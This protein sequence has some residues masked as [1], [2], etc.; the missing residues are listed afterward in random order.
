MANSRDQHY[1][2]KFGDPTTGEADDEIEGS[3]LNDW[4]FNANTVDKVLDHLMTNGIKTRGGDKLGKTIIFARNHKHAIYIEERFNLNYPEYSGKFLRVIDNYDPKAEDLLKKFCYDRAEEDPQIA[5][6][7]DML[8]TGVDAPRVVNLVFF[9]P[10]KSAVKYWQMIGRGTRLFPNLFA[11]GKHKEYFLIFDFCGNFE[12]FNEIPEGIIQTV[13]KSISQQLF[14]TKLQIAMMIRSNGSSSEEE[15]GFAEEYIHQLHQQISTLDDNRFI[16]RQ[17]LRRVN[18]YSHAERWQHVS[19]GDFIELCNHLSGLPPV[20]EAEDETARR[21]DLIVLKLQLAIILGNGGRDS[22]INRIV[23]LAGRLMKKR[24][25]PA[26]NEKTGTI[27]AVQSDEFWEHVSL[28]QLEKVRRD[29]RDLIKF[30]DAEEKKIVY[31]DFKDSIGKSGEVEIIPPYSERKN[32]RE[33]VESFVRKNRGFLVIHKILNNV[34]ITH[35]E[36]KQLERMLFDGEV[37]TKE[38]YQKEYGDMPLVKFIRSLLGLDTDAARQLFSGFIRAGNLKADQITFINQIIDFL[39]KNGTIDK[40]M[41][42][43]SP[44]TDSH[45]QGISGLFDDE[46]ARK[47][48]KIIDEVNEGA[49]RV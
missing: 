31:T 17:E 42:Y 7:V 48:V 30:I 26:V 28:N 19:K 38:D 21:F 29:L 8:D 43:E 13:Q 44:F 41:L 2:E 47:I 35:E 11:P 27:K 22:L 12:F 14:E 5:V 39:S 34:Q 49:M 24:N 4:L 23:N 33:R 20:D 9:K 1:E 10:V 40:S 16:V 36:L 3:A 15:L 32:Y 6:S 18:E 46:Q 45:D 25:I 37:G